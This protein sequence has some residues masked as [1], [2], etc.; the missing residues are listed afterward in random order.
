MLFLSDYYAPAVKVSTSMQKAGIQIEHDQDL[1]WENK[2][3]LIF[4]TFCIL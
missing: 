3:T 2:S 4:N 1:I